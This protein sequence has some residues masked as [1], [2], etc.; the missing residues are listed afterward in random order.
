MGNVVHVPY[1]VEP[2]EDGGWCAHA[3]LQP[4][5]VAHG[6]G[7]TREEAVADLRQALAGVVAV[8]GPPD[9]ITLTATEVA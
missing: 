3:Q 6:E 8:V 5:V 9:E 2:D 7:E 1:T 4:G